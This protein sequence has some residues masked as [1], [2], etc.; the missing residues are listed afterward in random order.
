MQS[1][2]RK[3][4]VMSPECVGCLGRGYFYGGEGAGGKRTEET[5]QCTLLHN[6]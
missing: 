3:A 5:P 2:Q 6:K 1:V 4:N